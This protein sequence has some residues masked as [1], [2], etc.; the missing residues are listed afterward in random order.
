MSTWM[1]NVS[2]FCLDLSRKRG[3]W[4]VRGK[5]IALSYTYYSAISLTYFAMVMAMIIQ[6]LLTDED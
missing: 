6:L 5:L 2:S 4:M 1:S 3:K